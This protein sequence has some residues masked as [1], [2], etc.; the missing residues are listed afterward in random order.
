M[1]GL[2]RV[3]TRTRPTASCGDWFNDA[4][5]GICERDV[6]GA[7]FVVCLNRIKN[8]RD[9]AHLLGRGWS[10]PTLCSFQPLASTLISLWEAAAP[11]NEASLTLMNREIPY[12]CYVREPSV[13]PSVPR[14]ET[15]VPNYIWMFLI[16]TKLM[17]AQFWQKSM[18]KGVPSAHVLH[19]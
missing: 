16:R 2:S 11:R 4:S 14:C 3:L 1:G 13:A 12:S 17:C 9:E 10:F 6:D 5:S 18:V 8:S 15:G 7:R 19:K